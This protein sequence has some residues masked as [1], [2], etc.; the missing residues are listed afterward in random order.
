MIINNH[1]LLDALICQCKCIEHSHLKLTEVYNEV[2]KRMGGPLGMG[3]ENE[4]PLR[5][6]R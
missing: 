4:D 1:E 5:S 2:V 3:K 6:G